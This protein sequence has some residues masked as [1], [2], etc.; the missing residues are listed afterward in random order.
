MPSLKRP[1]DHLNR[2][3]DKG[4]RLQAS[5]TIAYTEDELVIPTLSGHLAQRCQ[6]VVPVTVFGSF[7]GL[8]RVC[9]L[10]R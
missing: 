4:R 2:S 5:R 10:N 3:L 1:L 9:P 8:E 6:V 7:G